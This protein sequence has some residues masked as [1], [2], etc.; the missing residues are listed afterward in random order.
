MAIF[1]NTI[2]IYLLSICCLAERCVEVDTIEN[3]DYISKNLMSWTQ[4][5]HNN[6]PLI[7]CAILLLKFE[8]VKVSYT[9]YQ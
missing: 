1:S 2:I 9:I 8:L 6:D 7:K 4:I 5:S 3:D